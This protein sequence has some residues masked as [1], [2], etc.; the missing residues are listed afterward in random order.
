MRGIAYVEAGL[1]GTRTERGVVVQAHTRVAESAHFAVDA[2]AAVVLAGLQHERGI[3]RVVI[4][5]R[6]GARRWHQ[7]AQASLVAFLVRVAVADQRRESAC[8][9]WCDRGRQSQGSNYQGEPTHNST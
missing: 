4:G 9:C 7:P 3:G 2:S 1:L 5:E 8:N 6:H